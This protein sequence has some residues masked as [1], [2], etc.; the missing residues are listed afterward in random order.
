MCVKEKEGDEEETAGFMLSILL[1][2]FSL[3]AALGPAATGGRQARSW[4][5][6]GAIF[7]GVGDKKREY[8]SVKALPHTLHERAMGMGM[9]M[10]ITMSHTQ[11]SNTFVHVFALCI[12]G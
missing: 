4:P 10:G 7:F 3:F 5:R 6:A 8:S 11:C 12:L 2:P 1:P 9:G